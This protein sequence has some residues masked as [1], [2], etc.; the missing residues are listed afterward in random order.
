[1]DKNSIREKNK[2]LR[3]TLDI[4]KASDVILSKI[5]L[6]KGFLC[7][8][9][10]LIFYPLKYEINLLPLVSSKDKNFYLPKTENGNLLICPFEGELKKSDFGVMEPVSRPVKDIS[11]ID[12]AFIPALAV[13]KELNRIGYGKGFYDRLFLNPDFKAKKIAVINKELITDKIDAEKFDVKVD[14]VISG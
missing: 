11:I 8:K 12:L 7:A 5:F 3:K 10:V 6:L 9:N 4:K 2:L 14:M 13:D 1:M